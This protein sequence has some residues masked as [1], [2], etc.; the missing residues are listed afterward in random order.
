MIEFN[1]TKNIRKSLQIGNHRIINFEK[2]LLTQYPNKVYD[3]IKK[4]KINKYRW[5]MFVNP[6]I[7]A[8]TV[9]WNYE[10]NYL[11]ILIKKR[12]YIKGNICNI[13]DIIKTLNNINEEDIERNWKII[14]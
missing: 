10:K 11:V 3:V 1:R 9:E 7:L 12:V 5:F 4:P 8:T 13:S 6:T 14:K 2:E